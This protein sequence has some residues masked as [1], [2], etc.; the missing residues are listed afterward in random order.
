MLTVSGGKLVAISSAGPRRGWFFRE[1]EDGGS[2]WTR[3]KSTSLDNPR[4]PP[5]ELEA[6]RL[7]LG[8]TRFA[9]EHLSEFVDEVEDAERNPFAFAGMKD[10]LDEAFADAVVP[11]EE[12][13]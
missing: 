1:C 13:R 2:E 6:Q 3:I 9:R 4:V 7:T 11:L 10:L 8:P 12:G 5:E